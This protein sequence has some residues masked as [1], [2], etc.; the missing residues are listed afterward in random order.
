MASLGRTENESNE[1][2]GAPS[3]DCLTTVLAA[4]ALSLVLARASGSPEFGMTAFA[5]MLQYFGSARPVR[6]L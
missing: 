3:G 4:S 5:A 2:T 1:P 6:R